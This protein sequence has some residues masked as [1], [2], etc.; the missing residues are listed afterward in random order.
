MK[1]F[2][3]LLLLSISSIF[4]QSCSEKPEAKPATY[5]VITDINNKGYWENGDLITQFDCPDSK[6]YT[7]ID[8]KSWDKIPVVNR[9]IQSCKMT[10]I[11]DGRS[12]Y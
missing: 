1:L 5:D 7:P 2:R 6:F 8:I 11:C 9:L 10:L 3:L 4:V 12:A